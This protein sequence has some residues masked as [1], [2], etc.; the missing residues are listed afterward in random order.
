MKGASIDIFPVKNGIPVLHVRPK[1]FSG[2][3]CQ[4]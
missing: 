3:T 2:M 1:I 4:T